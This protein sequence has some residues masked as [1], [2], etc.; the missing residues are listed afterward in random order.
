MIKKQFYLALEFFF[1]FLLLALG[2][3]SHH[4]LLVW[5]DTSTANIFQGMETSS[6]TSILSLVSKVISPVTTSL[7]A[8][9]LIT[10]TWI[11]QKR[12]ALWLGSL[13]FGGNALALGI[14]YLVARPRPTHQ[15]ILVTGYSFPSGHTISTFLL[16]VIA[17]VL[18]KQGRKV[19]TGRHLYDIFALV[20]LTLVILSRLYL[21]NHYLTDILGSILL[22][23][24]YYFG[25]S[26]IFPVEKLRN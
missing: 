26:S 24:S 14:K 9:G 22:G 21:G 3:V 8:L 18:L 11:S 25:L 6:L 15:V 20:I 1:A 4:S 23:T 2:V 12:L 19:V 13:F 16:L 17:L 10:Y 5:V 7:V